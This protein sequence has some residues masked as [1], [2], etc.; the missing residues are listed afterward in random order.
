M[1]SNPLKARGQALYE[2]LAPEGTDV[3]RAALALE[4]ARMADRLDELDHVHH[5]MS[6]DELFKLETVSDYV[7]SDEVAKVEVNVKVNSVVSEARQLATAFSTVLKAL[8]GESK[9]AEAAKPATGASEL[10]KKR[11]ARKAARQAAQ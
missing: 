11:E 7:R 6:F 1:T 4:A 10:E 9:P 8:T 3:A 5:T 2:H